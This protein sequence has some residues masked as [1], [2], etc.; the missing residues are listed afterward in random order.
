MKEQMDAVSSLVSKG[1]MDKH[2]RIWLEKCSDYKNLS[3][4]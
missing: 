2:F 3:A 4:S 1:C